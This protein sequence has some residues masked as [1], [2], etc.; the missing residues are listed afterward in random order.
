MKH[1]I[2]GLVDPTRGIRY[3]GYTSRSLR[4]RL[5][6]HLVESQKK[7]TCHRHHWIRSLIS[8]GLKPEIVELEECT[9]KN[10]MKRERYWILKLRTSCR[11]VNSTDGGEGLLNPSE[12]TRKRMSKARRARVITDETCR[13]ISEANKGKNTWM[14][15]RKLSKETRAKLSKA[16]KGR[17]FTA[18]HCAKISAALMGHAVSDSVRK[19]VSEAH[20]KFKHTPETRAQISAS[21]TGNHTV[22]KQGRASIRAARTGSR[23]VFNGTR[24]RWLSAGDKLPRGWRFARNRA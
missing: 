11:L 17:K 15:G 9:E 23:I 6:A 5:R 10:W 19:A 14:L 4:K 20:R 16:R 13:R 18:E 2:Y 21:L 7:A 22:S 3:I 12:K 8:R 1:V 24:R